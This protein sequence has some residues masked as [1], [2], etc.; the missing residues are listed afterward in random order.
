MASPI[1]SARNRANAEDTKA[2][3]TKDLAYRQRVIPHAEEMAEEDLSM[4]DI[5]DRFVQAGVI[6]SAAAL[7]EKDAGLIERADTEPAVV[8]WDACG[9][10]LT[11]RLINKSD[12]EAVA[13]SA[14]AAV[15]NDLD[16][17][18]FPL[19]NRDL[20][21]IRKRRHEFTLRGGLDDILPRREFDEKGSINRGLHSG[22]ITPALEFLDHERRLERCTLTRLA[23]LNLGTDRLNCHKTFNTRWRHGNSGTGGGKQQQYAGN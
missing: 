1:R 23:V 21:R 18:K 16:G 7:A 2:F 12:L 8:F 22:Y 20:L 14:D 13:R 6:E 11:A 9:A 3:A 19:V 4:G 10:L 15:E 5:E 17:R